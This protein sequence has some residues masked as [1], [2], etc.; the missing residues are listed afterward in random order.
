[1]TRG[2]DN[3]VWMTSG[4]SYGWA[5]WSP[6]GGYTY[7]SPTVA[8][9]GQTGDMLVSYVN[10]NSYIPNYRTYSSNGSPLGDWC[11]D[12]TYWQTVNAVGL[13]YVGGAIYAII[14][15]LNGYVYYKQAYNG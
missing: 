13:S 5:S 15:G 2:E 9:N 10:E 11:Q 3:Q 4:Y 8:V 7:A 12:I 1:V 6:Q 14:T